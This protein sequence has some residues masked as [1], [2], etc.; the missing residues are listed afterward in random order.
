MVTADR[1]IRYSEEIAGFADGIFIWNTDD[2]WGSIKADLG[3]DNIN[4]YLAGTH[5]G[6]LCKWHSAATAGAAKR[7][8][9]LTERL[10]QLGS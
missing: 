2:R 4:M 7:V 3:S 9:H 1:G 5:G 10:K 6:K 8:P